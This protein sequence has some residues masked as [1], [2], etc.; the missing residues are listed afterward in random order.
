MLFSIIVPIYNVEKYL[1]ACLN[2]IKNQTYEN[3][4]VIMVNDGS[5]DNS[6]VIAE[7]YLNDKRF[8]LFNKEN[9]GLSDARNYGIEKVNCEYFLLIDSDDTINPDLLKSLNDVIN[10][11][12]IIR[13]GMNL[14][15]NDD[16]KETY[17]PAFFMKDSTYSFRELIKSTI[18]ESACVYCYNTKFYRE[19]NFKF[20]LK[21]YHED[22]GLIPYIIVSANLITS[23]PYY[24]YNYIKRKNSITTND[25]DLIKALDTLYHYDN[26]INALDNNI[27]VSKKSRKYYKSFLAN[28]IIN[29]AK[30]LTGKDKENFIKEIKKR[31]VEKYL[32]KNN[33]KRY[34][35]YLIIKYN[36][37]LFI[38]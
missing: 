29:K 25:K 20:A 16:I 35:K 10:T 31:H 7:T 19:N 3:F 30:T 9:G 24:G 11:E 21:K 37:E 6:K 26:L 28:S 8:K 17:H 32:L 18:F 14:V 34:I 36:I 1:N 38:R 22:F 13:F 33:L 15:E 12:D 27:K 4:E 2:S 5:T 23:I